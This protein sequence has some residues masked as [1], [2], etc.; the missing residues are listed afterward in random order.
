MTSPLPPRGLP[1]GAR[2]SL[3]DRTAQAIGRNPDRRTGT[4]I[5][6]DAGSETLTVSVGG[7]D[8]EQV[9]YLGTYTPTPGDVV[10]LVRQRSTWLCLGD[11]RGVNSP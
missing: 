9:G 1:S 10:A 5:S 6:F 8:P 11:I 3:A 2:G 7:G 4:V